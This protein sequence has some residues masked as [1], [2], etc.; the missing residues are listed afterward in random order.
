MARMD[1]V[2]NKASPTQEDHDWFEREYPPIRKAIRK[3][4]KHE[5]GDY[6]FALDDVEQVVML[7]VWLEAR[8]KYDPSRATVTTW[9]KGLASKEVLWY[10]TQ[11]KKKAKTA[12]AA[13]GQLKLRWMVQRH[14][15]LWSYTRWTFDE[16]V[17]C[18]T[19]EHQEV[20]ILRIY[21]QMSASATALTLGKRRATVDALYE[22]ALIEARRWIEDDEGLRDLSGGAGADKLLSG[23]GPGR[24]GKELSVMLKGER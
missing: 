15:E 3:H 17:D 23:D 1:E 2:L 16:I 8:E 7:R 9:V 11:E 14:E 13:F 18:L 6:Y 5:L 21:Y 22:E 4:I 20:L 10:I 24:P 12:K 19:P